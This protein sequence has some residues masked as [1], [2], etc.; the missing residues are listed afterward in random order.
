VIRLELSNQ[1]ESSE[2][3]SAD[4]YKEFLLDEEA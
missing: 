1:D 4:D 3:L 2:L